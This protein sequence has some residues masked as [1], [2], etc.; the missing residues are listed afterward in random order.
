M[1]MW[2]M[3]V[4]TF[5]VVLTMHTSYVQA[6]ELTKEEMT[7]VVETQ[8]ENTE[9]N[10]T[11]EEQAQMR[12]PRPENIAHAMDDEA[13]LAEIE[14][15]L[16]QNEQN[17]P[18][19]TEGMEIP[20]E[21]FIPVLMYHHFVTEEIEPGNGATIHI[22][23]FENHLQ[24]FI[25]E[26]YTIINLEEMNEILLKAIDEKKDNPYTGL[27]LD[28]K[29]VCI[30]I[31]DGYRSNYELA[32][33]LLLKY[34]V[35]ADISVITCRIHSDYVVASEIDKMCWKDLNEMQE[36]G[37]VTIYTHTHD[38]TP[39]NENDIS[40]F[41]DMVQRSEREL[42]KRLENRGDFR[43]LTYPNGIYTTVS[44]HIM[45]QLGYDIQ[46]STDYGVVTRDTLVNAIPR[47]TVNSGESGERLLER[48]QAAA[49]NSFR[50]KI[51]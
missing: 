22:D 33:P 13:L 7:L 5:A 16:K 41:R 12:A 3:A 11:V 47:V 34:N 40:Y 18:V 50:D 36:S 26:G 10:D 48:I 25:N 20:P 46:L 38:H 49:N 27:R 15:V 35:K 8:M 17:H 2:N 24:T 44:K 31:D 23:E 4:M 32:Y 51:L 43:V 29:Y 30:T 21:E 42:D 14:E 39:A 19:V 9:D 45:R 37:L 28:K 6:D 1:N